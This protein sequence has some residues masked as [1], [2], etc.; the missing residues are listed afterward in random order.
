M[1]KNNWIFWVLA[2]IITISAAFYQKITGPTYPKKVKFSIS[3]VQEQF[4]FPRS[5]PGETD[6]LLELPINDKVLAAKLFYKKYPTN[7]EWTVVEM[8]RR[9]DTLIASLPNQPPAGKLE[10][11][12]QLET[13]TGK[14][15]IQKDEPVIIR[16]RGDVPA[17]IMIP[18]IFFIFFAML[19]S[20]LAGILAVANVRSF[21]FYGRMAFFLLLIGGMIFGPI[22]QKF[23]FNELWAGVPFGWDLTDNKTLIAFVGWVF[24]VILNMKKERRWA[25]IFAALLTIII[26][27]IPHSMFG[28][29]LDPATGVIKQA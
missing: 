16:F 26:F 11:Y 13:E 6:C 22:V 28:S 18:H 4:I 25:I 3:G 29:E 12:I 17:Y 19:I 21:R 5:H 14:I 8:E 1:K 7:A 27:S 10:Y 15:D 2:V 20:N 24:A 9:N 23:A